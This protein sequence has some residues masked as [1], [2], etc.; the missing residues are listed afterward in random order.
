[1][2][3]WRW[4]DWLP[5]IDKALQTTLGEGDTPLV[6]S[7][8]IG[9]AIGLHNLFFKLE[10]VNPSGS[11]KDRFA[12]MAVSDMRARNQ[13]RCVTTSSGNTGSA[14][15]AYCGASDISCEIS[16]LETTPL[17]KLKQMQAY[18]AKLQRVR[19]FG[20]NPQVTQHVFDA[21]EHLA[22]QAD[23][24]LHI[25]AFAYS[26]I[27][28]TAVQTIAY[29]LAEQTR[30][31]L[32]HVFCP[33]GGGGLTLAVAKGFAK[34]Q[35]K[36]ALDAAVRVQC[37]QPTGN[38]TIASPLRDGHDRA[39][40]VSCTSLISGLQV[41][42][43]IDGHEVIPACRQTGGSGHV[44]SDEEVWQVQSRLAREEGI[45]CEPAGAIALAGAINAV[46][47]KRISP[48][49]QVVC[50][51]TGSAFKDPPS[52]DRMVAGQT[53]PTI[54]PEDLGQLS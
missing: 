7:K 52:I 21:L 34:A 50:L 28:M 49:S 40:A 18:G 20:T 19:G 5:P 29:E 11:Y 43:V 47:A 42:S 9:P 27:A 14:L 33:A 17:G 39:Q 31:R 48:D 10:L 1:M 37:V 22:Q 30:G 8:H 32:D 51:V 23:T 35:Q 45:F 54:E 24:A 36:G 46:K 2:S 6:R 53:C 26:P 12:A 25:S 16:I 13:N 4:D 44:V 15:A 3:I 38:D 41:A